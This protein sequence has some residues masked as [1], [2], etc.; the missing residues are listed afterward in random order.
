MSL[1]LGKAS[2]DYVALGDV[3]RNVN[4]TV[5]D[6]AASGIDRVVAMDH[7]D[8]GELRIQRWGAIEDGTTFTRCVK[9]G[10]TLFGKRRAY[11]RKVAYAEFDAICSG[12]ILT[13]E[14]VEGRM[15]P[16]F[17]PFVVQSNEFFDHALGTSAGSLSPRTNW[18]DLS[19]FEF[20]LPPFDKQRRIA[21]LL[22]AIARHHR[23]LQDSARR[24]A[25]VMA[26][27]LDDARY[28]DWPLRT[29]GELG[30]VQLGQQLHPKYR[31]G[32]NVRRYLRVAN[33]LDDR[34]DASDV[35]EMDFSDRGSEK[36]RLEPGDVLLNEGQS[37]ELVG[38]CAMFRG[39]IDD[40]YMQKTLLRF[41]AGEAIL[42]DFALAWFGRCFLR[43]E[44]ARLA[45]RTT[46][47]AHLTAVRFA[48]MPMPVPSIDEQR[49]LIARTTTLKRARAA[50]G[51]EGSRLEGLRRSVFGNIFGA[52]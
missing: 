51:D 1:G 20:A 24:I 49:D 25:D 52:D 7:L 21:D 2:W 44:F 19:T 15:L 34:I 45:K 36:F 29:V 31:S 17:L 32:L 26:H 46:S 38:R 48:A 43:G 5:R 28:P 50:I 23:A 10:Q 22:W 8:P 4:V 35:R 33:V 30:D 37:I 18:R 14:A 16:Q 40:C 41:R 47:M 9:P 11:Q 27:A 3:V 6:P 42:P 12:D 39:E 13:F